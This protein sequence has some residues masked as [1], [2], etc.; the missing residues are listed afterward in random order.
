MKKLPIGLLVGIALTFGFGAVAA[1]T[2]LPVI[3]G[4]TATT[5]A[6]GGGIF[7]AR[8]DGLGFTQA[9]S[10]GN[11]T[12]YWDNTN[13]RL[14]VGSTSPY[15]MFSINP[16]GIGTAPAFV[17]GSSTATVF[18]VNPSGQIQSNAI[19]PATSTT[20]TLDWA[21]TPN[22]VEYRIGTSATTIT[23]I[24][25]TT[26]QFWGSRKLVWICNPTGT[27]GAITWAGVEWIGATV[28]TQTTTS[29]A[30]D[31]YSFDVTMATSSSAW[32]VAGSQGANF[33]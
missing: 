18:A 30:C 33:Q 25:A 3:Q 26:S 14:G 11:A 24:N 29:N 1:T 28:P 22:Q 21:N 4:G 23:L 19:Q 8:A 2:V 13:F 10:T 15:G 12:L 9:S 17:I 6:Y 20:M 27:A 31:V 32:K 16:N 7:F 5:T